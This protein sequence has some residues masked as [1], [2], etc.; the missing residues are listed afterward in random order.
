MLNIYSCTETLIAV[1]SLQTVYTIMDMA[2]PG[3]FQWIS[4][5]VYNRLRQ[6]WTDISFLARGRMLGARAQ[7]TR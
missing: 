6:W 1:T 3:Q 4:V 7:R 2:T 5:E